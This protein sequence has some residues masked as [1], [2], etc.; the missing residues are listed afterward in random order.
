MSQESPLQEGSILTV[1]ELTERVRG[2]IEEAV[3]ECW[4]RGEVSNLRRQSSGHVYFSLKDADAQLSC[5]L[6]RGSAQ[7]QQVSIADGRQLLVFGRIDVYAP[8]G[9]YQCIVRHVLEDGVGRLQQAYEALR[10]KLYAEGLFEAE[11]K[12]PLPDMPATVGIITS[13]TGA[14]LRDF[15]SILKRRGWRGRLVVLPARV[16]GAESAGEIVACIEQAERMG[17]LDLLVLARGGGSLEDLWSFND[18]AVVRAVADCAIPTLSGIGH[19]IDTTLTDFAADRRAETPSGAAELISSRFLELCDQVLQLAESMQGQ[20]QLVCERLGSRLK[21][22]A[23]RLQAYSPER[24]LEYLAQRVDDLSGRLHNAAVGCFRDAVH[25]SERSRRAFGTSLLESSLRVARKDFARVRE[26]YI[27]ASDA[28]LKNERERLLSLAQRLE[29]ASY[30][31]ALQRGFSVMRD[32]AGRVVMRARG[33]KAGD[34][35]THEFQDGKLTSQVWDRRSAKQKPRP[36][37]E[38][39]GSSPSQGELF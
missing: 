6:F 32:E 37:K 12:R 30:Q 35:L 11:R 31:R 19:E 5:V 21:H 33:V 16:Q 14:A 20:S 17:V 36:G 23:S 15:V 34:W 9:S 3:P 18:E 25:R 13:P 7:R 2:A 38:D 22:Q 27:H 4:I 29:R 8:R 10:Q 1:G 24:R 28:Y 26:A 39:D